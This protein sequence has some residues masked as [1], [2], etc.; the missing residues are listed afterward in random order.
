MGRWLLEGSRHAK[1]MPPFSVAILIITLP[2]RGVRY[3]LDVKRP[4]VV[5]PKGLSDQFAPSEMISPHVP[6][7]NAA[8]SC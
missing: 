8:P 4:P 1:P 7:R 5:D 2:G 6:G 3:T